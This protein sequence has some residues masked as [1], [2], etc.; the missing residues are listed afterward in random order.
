MK[1][2]LSPAVRVGWVLFL[3]ALVTGSGSAFGGELDAKVEEVLRVLDSKTCRVG[4]CFQVV[5]EE[6]VAYQKSADDLLIPASNQKMLT[7]AAALDRLGPEY[8]FRTILLQ[9]GEDLGVIGSGDVEFSARFHNGDSLFTLRRWA[10]ELKKR[11]ISRIGNIELDSSRFESTRYH[12]RWEGSDIGAWFAAEVT[13]FSLNDNCVDCVIPGK[14]ARD[15]KAQ[16]VLEPEVGFVRLQNRTTMSQPRSRSAA[17]VGRIGKDR[18]L[19]VR[20]AVAPGTKI[21]RY[22][23]AVPDP[24]RY[25]GHALKKSLQEEGIVVGGQILEK[26]QSFD[27]PS[28]KEVSRVETPL[29]TSLPVIGK[30]SQ[31]LY[32]EVVF[33][34]LAL[35]GGES[36]ASW[37]GGQR[38]MKNILSRMG[39]SGDSFVVSDGSGL[40]RENRVTPRAFVNLC[41]IMYSHAT[42]KQFFESLSVS[43]VDGTLTRRLSDVGCKGRV[44]AKTGTLTGVSALSGILKAKSGRVYAFSM[45]MNRRKRNR[46]PSGRTFKNVQDKICRLFIEA[47]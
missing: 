8:R 31:N 37:E 38:E 32:A 19:R 28:W 29:M 23:V 36:Q 2:V 16:V 40:S 46:G 47:G 45:I 6:K 26:R 43:G 30:K 9:K 12:P 18:V 21:A 35:S 13:A 24:T 44:I 42:R 4:I 1:E 17:V 20:G 41:R 5:D 7:M 27:M 3:C 10:K 25:F 34:T 14:G 22:W 39:L 11:G 33:K 15:G